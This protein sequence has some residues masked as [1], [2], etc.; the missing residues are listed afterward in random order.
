[1]KNLQIDLPKIS[2]DTLL[3]SYLLSPQ[4][5]RHNLDEL[6]L[7][8]FKKVKIP[9]EDLIGKGKKQQTLLEAPLEKVKDYCCEDSD[10]TCRLKEHFEEELKHK[11]LETLFY[12]IELPLLSILAKMERT[13]IYLDAAQIREVGSSLTA[14]LDTIQTTIFRAVGEEFNLNS[15]KQLSQVLFE[16]LNLKP[17]R[18]MSTSADVLEELAV[19]CPIVQE[20]LNYRA[21]EKLRSTYAESL[22]HFIHPNTHRIHC[23]F[24]QSG[25]ATGRL[26]CQDPNLQNIP[27]RSPEGLAI[28]ACFKPQK[29]GWRFLGADYSQIELRLLAHFSE[30]PELLNAFQQGGDIHTHTASLVFDVPQKEVSSAMRDAAKTVNFGILYGQSPFGL[31]RQLGI[32]MHEAA[33]FIKTYFKRYPRVSEY[34]E[35]CKELTRKTGVAKTLIGRLRPIPEINNKNPAIR[36]GAE[37]LAV[38]TPLQGT[39]ADLIKMAMIEIDRS[40]QEQK[41]EGA[42]ILQIHD[43]LIFEIPEEETASF[44]TLVKEKME[45]VLTLNVPI[46]VHLAVGKNWAE[47]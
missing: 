25:T 27:V 44:E 43:E 38:N 9:L 36:A 40:L 8:V 31:S 14:K 45:G 37:R 16:T 30:D 42:M 10:Y 15:P 46:E 5:R 35:S 29:P 39:A 20:I 21:L 1:L 26:A 2:F 3:A 28:R 24:N 12:Q 23:T 41:L 32:S 19:E 13:G 6:T 47:C 34:L 4:K 7:E 11:K 22:P 33:T 18:K 17:P